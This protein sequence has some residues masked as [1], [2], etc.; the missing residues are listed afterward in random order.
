MKMRVFVP[1]DAV[2]DVA[3]RAEAMRKAGENSVPRRG[4]IPRALAIAALLAVIV[5]FAGCNSSTPTTAPAKSEPKAPELLTGRSAFYKAFIA[6]PNYAADA[7]PFRIE[8][9]PSSYSNG[10]EGKPAIWR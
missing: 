6:A 9:T 5:A 8:S 2:V 3:A 10:Q 7:K 4:S 1:S